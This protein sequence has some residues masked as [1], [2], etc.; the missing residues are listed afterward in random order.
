MIAWIDHLRARRWLVLHFQRLLP[1]DDD[2]RL[3]RHLA[4]CCECRALYAA[5]CAIEGTADDST[6]ARHRRLESALFGP[7]P[8]EVGARARAR[9][10]WS[11]AVAATAAAL[12]IVL[13]PAA[14]TVHEKGSG[15]LSASRYVSVTVYGRQVDGALRRVEGSIHRH[16]PLAFSFLNRSEERFDHLLLFGVDERYTVYWF[17]PAWTDPRQS[18]AAFALPDPAGG[19]LHEEVTHTFA[20]SRLRIFA[21]FTRERGLTVRDI[22]ERVQHLQARRVEIER[23]EQFPL[24]ES[25]QHTLLLEVK[26]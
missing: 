5:Q 23:L 16:Q 2:R 26:P 20:G 15:A 6:A 17:Y 22:E 19:Q 12:L 21:L 25:G 9:L 1:L 11:V 8:A 24:P 7:D 3:R 10:V 13:W 18:P 14:P 4:T